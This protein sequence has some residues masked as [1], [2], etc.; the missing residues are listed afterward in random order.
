MSVRNTL[1]LM[2]AVII[3]QVGFAMILALMVSAISKGKQFFRIV[4]FFPVVISATAL[5]LLFVLMYDY[6]SGALN[7]LMIILGHEPVWWLNETMR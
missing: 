7:Q 1:Y 6:S 5:G 2:A 3:F 4:F